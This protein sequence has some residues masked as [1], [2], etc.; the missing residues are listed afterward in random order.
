MLNDTQRSPIPSPRSRALASLAF[1][2]MVLVGPLCS[3]APQ[4]PFERTEVRQDCDD[5]RALRN[6]YFGDTHVHTAYSFDA[7]LTATRLTPSDAY[8]FAQGQIVG[9]QPYD[10]FDQPTR[11]VQIDRSLDFA[12]VTDHA[13]FLGVITTCTTPGLPGYDDPGCVQYREDP[14]TAL[15]AIGSRLVFDPPVRPDL[16]GPGGQ[17]CIDQDGVLWSEIQD[18]AEAAYDR[19]SACSFT[20]FVGYEWT[21]NTG[22]ANR[23]RNVI[24]RNADVP[25]LPTSVVDAPKKE[26]LWDAL[27]QDCL[28]GTPDCDVLAIPHNSNLA[29][30]FFFETIDKNG[31]PYTGGL[32]ARQASFEPLLEVYQT[33]GNSECLPG[34]SS[35][36]ELCDFEIVP[37]NNIAGAIGAGPPV[38]ADYV[39]YALEEGM[40][41]E[42][43][44]G[45]N[46]FKYGMIA[47]TDTHIATPG[48]VA[49][50]EQHPGHGASAD[51]AGQPGLTDIPEYSPGGLA[52]VWAEENS[53]DSIFEAMRRREAY[54]TS[55]PRHIVR[56]F[57]G[58]RYPLD[59]CSQNDA[60][61]K[62]D[63]MGVP[64]GGD[65]APRLGTDW[66]PRFFATALK[67][68]G[69]PQN[70]GTDL[71]RIQIVKG[72]IDAQ[73]DAQEMIYDVAGDPDN[74]ATVN[75]NTCETN[76]TG[77]TFL[78]T[79]WEDP[80]FDPTQRAFYYARVI[81]NPTCRWSQRQCNAAA[82]D[83]AVPATITTG[84][85]A[86]CDGSI[87]ASVRERSWTSPIWY[88]P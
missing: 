5:F 11:F 57:G 74:G 40:A 19:T 24:F 75:P 1:L 25:A 41:Q 31:N 84:F 13:E 22:A 33:K 45:A 44:L 68:V 37:W 2:A 9:I 14:H 52:V 48:L 7:V 82:V 3:P 85:E 18:D 47:S 34:T 55:G 4:L 66:N 65:L 46:P 81:E 88:T 30:G 59:L 86:C 16:C 39:R 17:Y 87:P 78:C 29:R 53:R 10:A 21:N 80:D 56:F 76:G 64:M 6:P 73:G 67:D 26:D 70:P 51:R 69:T 27:E 36:D 42:A 12:V 20:T 54:A 28:I 71:Q 62:A 60:V 8:A 50:S 49:E 79:V 23:H 38:P 77:F 72:W 35:N 63:N 83:C 58:W 61:L 43:A 15:A 32:A